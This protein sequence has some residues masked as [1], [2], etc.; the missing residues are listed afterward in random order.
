MNKATTTQI[1]NF[2]NSVFIT[3]FT[4]ALL[5]VFL[6][7]FAFMVFT[8]MKN[9]EQITTVGAPIWPAEAP[10]FEYNGQ[11]L[12]IF[13]VPLPDGTTRELALHKKG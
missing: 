1:R 13:K 3:S 2:A 9:Q 5:I 6:A 10:K 4:L 7:P 11:N 8:S 12:E